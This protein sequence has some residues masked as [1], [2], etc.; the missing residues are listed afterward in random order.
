MEAAFTLLD[1]VV[2]RNN[3]RQRR[4]W[5]DPGATSL[6]SDTVMKAPNDEERRLENLTADYCE[7]RSAMRQRLTQKTWASAKTAAQIVTVKGVLGYHSRT[8][9]H[10]ILKPG[11]T[12][13]K[14]ALTTMKQ[15]TRRNLFAAATTAVPLAALAQEAPPKTTSRDEDLRSAR[16]TFASNAA[17]L[18]KV[19][20]PIATEPAF[21]F[22]A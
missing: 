10:G 7:I 18:A 21:V 9:A 17:L 19:E 6:V 3:F 22:K 16:D 12:S 5:V 4:V 1:R 2:L 13:K 11:S 8:G 15:I 20:L 14:E